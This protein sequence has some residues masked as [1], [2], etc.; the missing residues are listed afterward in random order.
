MNLENKTEVASWRLIRFEYVFKN[1]YKHENTID[2]Y[3]GKVSFVNNESEQFT[4]K[5]SEE[6]SLKFM[7][8]IGGE[9]IKTASEFNEKI[10]KSFKKNE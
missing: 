3:E 7:D 1:G 10:I 9:L 6:T 2:R 4:I 8:I 5:I